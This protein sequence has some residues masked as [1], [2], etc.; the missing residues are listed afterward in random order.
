[1]ACQ[2]LEGPTVFLVKKVNVAQWVLLVRRD[3]QDGKE[4]KDLKVSWD[5]EGLLEN[6][7]RKETLV[8]QDHLVKMVLTV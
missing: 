1:M 7:L 3:R 2:D 5:Q 8:H 6:Q 4:S